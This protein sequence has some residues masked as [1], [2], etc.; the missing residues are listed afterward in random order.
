M[1]ASGVVLKPGV[2]VL[3]EDTNARLAGERLALQGNSSSLS[4]VASGKAFIAGNRAYLAQSVTETPDGVEVVTAE[5]TFEEVIESIDVRGETTLQ[6]KDLQSIAAG[7]SVQ[8]GSSAALKAPVNTL[9]TT[10]VTSSYILFNLKDVV[11]ANLNPSSIPAVQ[12]IANG[13]V[14]LDAP[15]IKFDVTSNPFAPPTV[16]LSFH[17]G[18]AADLT[19]DAPAVSIDHTWVVPLAAFQV[20]VPYTADIVA[21]GGRI[22]LILQASG[23]AKV[24][25]HFTEDATF[26]AGIVGAG[27]PW[28]LTPS[29]NVTSHFNADVPSF[30]GS[31]TLGAYVGPRLSL[32][33]FQYD[34]A[35]I[36]AK[37][38]FNA[39]ATADVAVAQQCINLGIN[40]AL[41]INGYFNLPFYSIDASIYSHSWPLYSNE[42][43]HQ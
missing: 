18:E 21:I 19:L 5:P 26:D 36:Y 8:S 16:N 37:A 11:V 20:P 32:L 17:G 1:K 13:T 6:T 42:F 34:L 22:D 9:V 40:A 2:A 14:R 4:E 7:A 39:T 43:C 25:V 28:T 12:I 35:G 27:N 31:V 23:E 38:G 10:D 3:G 30:Q 15:T 41:G 24:V 33:I 29:S